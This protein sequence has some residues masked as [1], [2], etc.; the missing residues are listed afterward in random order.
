MDGAGGGMLAGFRV[1][2]AADVLRV[3]VPGLWVFIVAAEC[4]PR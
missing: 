2:F 1:V 3:P 4:C